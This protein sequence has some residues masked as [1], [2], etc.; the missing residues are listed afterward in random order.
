[1]GGAARWDGTT[2]GSGA[3]RWSWVGRLG[4]LRRGAVGHVPDSVPTVMSASDRSR[5]A[6]RR[7][8][9]AGIVAR[10]LT[11]HFGEVRAVDGVDLEVAAGEV[12]GFL[13]PNS[14]GKTLA[15]VRD[16]GTA[17]SYLTLSGLRRRTTP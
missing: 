9:D 2:T 10:G 15:A 17:S 11:R 14:A 3:A 5:E 13:G 7:N 16:I 6:D 12:Y 4:P 1:M 8:G